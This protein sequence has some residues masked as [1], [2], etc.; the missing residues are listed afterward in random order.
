MELPVKYHK[1]SGYQRRKVREQYVR[2][3]EGKCYHCGAPLEGPPTEDI[4]SRW[5]YKK[6]FPPNFFDYPVHLHHNHDTDLTIGAV[7]CEC[8]AVLWQYYG[9]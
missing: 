8:N 2:I 6:L 7:H 5:I 9:E 4:T 3:Q 1:I